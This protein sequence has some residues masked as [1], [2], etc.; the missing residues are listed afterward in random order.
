LTY[1]NKFSILDVPFPQGKANPSRRKLLKPKPDTMHWTVTDKINL[2]GNS[3]IIYSKSDDGKYLKME[4]QDTFHP[5]KA[6]SNGSYIGLELEDGKYYYAVSST[7]FPEITVDRI[8][9][10]EER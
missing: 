7:D 10:K 5:V 4:Y 6:V 3:H 9:I 8:Y 1:Q 2:F